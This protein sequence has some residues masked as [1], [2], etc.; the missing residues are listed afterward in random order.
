MVVLWY[1]RTTYSIHSIE[2]P[3]AYI[4]GRYEAACRWRTNPASL[5][6]PMLPPSSNRCQPLPKSRRPRRRRFPLQPVLSRPVSLSTSRR[7][8]RRPPRSPLRPVQGRLLSRSTSRRLPRLSR[9]PRLRVRAASRSTRFCPVVASHQGGEGGHCCILQSS[10]EMT[11]LR[12]P[13]PPNY[14]TTPRRA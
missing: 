10:Q 5:T 9:P 4:M 7:Q 1:E 2:G 13:F 3:W 12:P 6:Y 8:L 11:A 14:F